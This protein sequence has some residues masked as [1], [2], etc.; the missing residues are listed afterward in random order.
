M[1]ALRCLLAPVQNY[2]RD[3]RGAPFSQYIHFAVFCTALYLHGVPLSS[4]VF[5]YIVQGTKCSAKDSE[6]YNCENSAP[7]TRGPSMGE[8]LARLQQVA[9]HLRNNSIYN[10]YIMYTDISI[11]KQRGS[12]LGLLPSCSN[13]NS[14]SVF[15][16]IVLLK[17]EQYN[18]RLQC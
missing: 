15:S 17:N 3:E 1:P 7:D 18:K 8:A 10:V 13:R 4:R 14:N 16:K 5:S 9:C 11:S 6:V 12:S 2:N